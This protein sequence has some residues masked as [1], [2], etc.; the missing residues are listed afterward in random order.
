MSTTAT[1]C[2]GAIVVGLG[3]TLFMDLWALFLKWVFNISP[4][5]YCCLQISQSN[6]GEA[7]KP[8]GTYRPRRG[9]ICMCGGHEHG[10]SLCLIQRTPCRQLGSFRGLELAR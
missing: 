1:Y 8:D 6:T 7:K 2:L 5:N 10:A 4:A 3:G 9:T